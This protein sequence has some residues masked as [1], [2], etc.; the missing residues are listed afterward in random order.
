M[1]SQEMPRVVVS[2][3]PTADTVGDLIKH[4]ERYDKG[5]PVWIFAEHTYENHLHLQRQYN[6]RD[7]FHVV[8]Y[9]KPLV[10]GS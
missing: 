1:E 6:E 2:P 10:P 9:G 8:I 4:L 7:G 3:E 5:L